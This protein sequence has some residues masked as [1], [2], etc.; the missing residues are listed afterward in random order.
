MLIYVC[1]CMLEWRNSERF[2]LTENVQMKETWHQ[3]ICENT[4]KI[5]SI[6]NACESPIISTD[7]QKIDRLCA[8]PVH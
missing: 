6:L 8:V 2:N 3:V 1:V 7:G 4:V 5:S